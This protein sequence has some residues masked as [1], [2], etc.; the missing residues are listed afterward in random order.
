MV[1]QVVGGQCVV[2]ALVIGSSYEVPIALPVAGYGFPMWSVHALPGVQA[3]D[4][5]SQNDAR[6]EAVV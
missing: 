6:G 2:F 5:D 1:S 4:L 3:K